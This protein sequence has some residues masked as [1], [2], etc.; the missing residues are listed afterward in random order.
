MTKIEFLE[1]LRQG[2]SSIPKKEADERINFYSEMIDD[3]I[4]DGL[5]EED[6]V[7]SVCSADEIISQI[8]SEDINL[9]A[10]NKK[11]GTKRKLKAWEIVLICCG[12]PIW[13]PLGVAAIAILIS[14]YAVLWSVL[15]ALWAVPVALIACLPASI[16]ILVTE[17]IAGNII[18]GLAILG[19]GFFGTGISIFAAFGCLR[20][21][22]GTLALSKLIILWIK[23][24]FIGK[25][26]AR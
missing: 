22:R 5:S 14:V 10:A 7:A 15:V 8:I 23:S 19:L 2:L 26:N 12:S 4:E 25:E 3:R 16:L 18:S 1:K 11:A 20:A 6:A 13:L 17:C 24:W 9:R 21:T